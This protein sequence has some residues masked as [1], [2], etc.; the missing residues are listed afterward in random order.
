LRLHIGDKTTSVSRQVTRWQRLTNASGNK[1][2]RAEKA[3]FLELLEAE[4]WI[5]ADPFG[6]LKV[7]S[8]QGASD[9]KYGITTLSVILRD[10]AVI[11]ELS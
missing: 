9:G 1:K 5:S 10:R 4:P 3:A 11:D 6:S 7:C 8:R 2:K